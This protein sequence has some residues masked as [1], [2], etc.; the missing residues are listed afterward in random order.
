MRSV[1]SEHVV[2]AAL[3]GILFEETHHNSSS[4]KVF[5]ISQW[6]SYNVVPR[7]ESGVHLFDDDCL[8][9]A[10]SSSSCTV[11]IKVFLLIVDLLMI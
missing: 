9:V 5:K 4:P 1:Y 7:E 10:L 11:C 6:L 3:M 8:E 2:P